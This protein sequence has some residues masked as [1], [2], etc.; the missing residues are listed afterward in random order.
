MTDKRKP[1]CV[2]TEDKTEWYEDLSAAEQ[3]YHDHLPAPCRIEH[4]F[5]NHEGEHVVDIPREM[6]DHGPYEPGIYI[7]WGFDDR[8]VRATS[9]TSDEAYSAIQET[10]LALIR[11]GSLDDNTSCFMFVVRS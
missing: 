4:H 1:Y 11:D 9:R 3:V 6:S 8:P 5:T 2:V 10:I 7:D